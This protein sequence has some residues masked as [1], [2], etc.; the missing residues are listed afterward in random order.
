MKKIGYLITAAIVL[1]SCGN[2][3]TPSNVQDII[4]QGDLE[5]LRSKKAEITEQQKVLTDDLRLLDS[6]ISSRSGNERLPLI[7]TITAKVENF[8]H[9]LELQGDVKTKQN[10]LVYPEMQG[11]LQ[12][13][14]VTEG[15]K[16]VKGQ[17]LASID[18]GGMGSQVDQLKTQAALAKTTFERQQRLW[19]QKIGSEIQYLQAKTQYEASQ[20]AV[21]QAESQLG[22]SAIRAPFA[23]I[24]DDVIKDQ[25]TVVAPGPGSEV[26]RIVNLDNMYIEVDVPENYLDGVQ[27][28]KEAIVYFPVLGDTV[29]S[30]IRQTG[31]FI[32]P[33]NRSF[34]IEISVPNKK[35]V[36][37]PNLTAKVSLND[38]S[39]ATAI[40]V[41]QNV[42]SENA[43]GQQYVY[44]AELSDSENEAVVSRRIITTGRTQGKMVEILT[45]IGDGDLLVKEGAR[46]VKEGQNVK[47]VN[48]Q[49]DE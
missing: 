40:L 8:D 35:G 11:T 44:V 32:K 7:T 30:I 6:V 37:K 34:S 29:H 20:N 42:I 21:R 43:E 22:K 12:K 17:L 27:K 2:G 25:G 13:V 46:I 33:D 5:A 28:G 9:F 24:I 16:V 31:N 19:D 47:I 23:G 49:S 48:D 45:G 3:S 18:D 1:T 14:Y 36:I 41:P 15:Q 26:F 4:A 38:Y 10:V 39:N